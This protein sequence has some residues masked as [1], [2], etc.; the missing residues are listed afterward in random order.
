MSLPELG[1]LA[2]KAAQLNEALQ[3]KSSALDTFRIEPNVKNLGTVTS[4]ST[5]PAAITYSYPTDT[6]YI[7]LA[8]PYVGDPLFF[9]EPS[10]AASASLLGLSAGDTITFG[11]WASTDGNPTSVTVSGVEQWGPLEVAVFFSAAASNWKGYGSAATGDTFSVSGVNTNVVTDNSNLALSQTYFEIGNLAPFTSAD[12]TVSSGTITLEGDLSSSISAGMSV[13]EKSYSSTGPKYLQYNLASGEYD[14]AVFASTS[15]LTAR[16]TAT[17]STN[18]TS[19]TDWVWGVTLIE[20][21]SDWVEWVV[22]AHYEFHVSASATASGQVGYV[23]V[24]WIPD[25]TSITATNMLIL[26]ESNPHG[27]GAAGM[28]PWDGNQLQGHKIDAYEMTT[29]TATSGTRYSFSMPTLI[30]STNTYFHHWENGKPTTA[31]IY[32]QYD[33]RFSGNAG[34]TRAVVT[35]RRVK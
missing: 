3:A 22:E 8:D 15:E 16:W 11:A 1:A 18:F 19:T 12:A 20:F 29:L 7:Q 33:P 10:A 14:N 25:P 32:V 2:A 6:S 5:E 26:N 34:Y 35:A 13:V 31:A 28:V 27:V 9:Y 21:P 4:V 23:D 30:Q 24:K 17:G